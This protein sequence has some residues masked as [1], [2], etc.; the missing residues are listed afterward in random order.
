ML[1]AG[2]LLLASSF[3]GCLKAWGASSELCPLCPLQ[4]LQYTASSSCKVVAWLVGLRQQGEA[5]GL[6]WG[7]T[8][9]RPKSNC[10]PLVAYKMDK[11]FRIGSPWVL[12]HVFTLYVGGK[13]WF[14]RWLSVT[15]P[16]INRPSRRS[17]VSFHLTD[18]AISV[19]WRAT[20]GLGDVPRR[21]QKGKPR[22]SKRWGT[23][24][25]AIRNTIADADM[26]Q[27]CT[28]GHKAVSV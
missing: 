15:H 26:F 14:A 20:K 13:N 2:L 12:N 5:A 17:R 25:A 22:R 28:L 24:A 19:A 27:E 9:P 8:S 16:L 10:Y 3:C 7:L 23:F 18:S 1:A 6:M 4:Y 11:Q 21:S